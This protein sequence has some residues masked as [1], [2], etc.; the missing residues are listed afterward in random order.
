[1]PKAGHSISAA[2][3][4][5]IAVEDF[6]DTS[7]TD[8]LHGRVTWIEP[9][10]MGSHRQRAHRACSLLKRHLPTLRRRCLPKLRS[11]LTRCSSTLA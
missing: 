3:F 1:M 4:E 10:P 5:I 8:A 9:S 11:A 2:S 7:E 6:E